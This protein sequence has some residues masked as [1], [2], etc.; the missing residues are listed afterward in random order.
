MYEPQGWLL[1]WAS[2]LPVLLAPSAPPVAESDVLLRGAD[3]PR[4]VLDE[5]V[6]HVRALVQ[7]GDAPSTETTLDVYV[8]GDD[9]ALCVFRAGPLAG[10]RILT[11]RDRVWLILPHTTHPIRISAN[12]RLFGGASITDVT[13]LRFAEEF[14]A[15][16][17]PEVD[18]V[19]GVVCHV[20]RLRARSSRA[21]Y[22]SGTLW[23]GTADGLARRARLSL[24]SGKEAKEM[25]FVAYDD[26]HGKPV[27][28]RLEIHHLLPTE[29]GTVTTLDFL[30]YDSRAVAPEWFDPQRARELP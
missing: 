30:G 17:D 9:H 23:V 1:A 14:R 5:G 22:A 7:Q 16:L 15:T 27:L 29:R 13:R 8:R 24:P 11:V 18:S 19:D 12:Q 20:L 6:L 28:R 2:L 4:H 21:A 3:A 25:R 26:Y 10:R